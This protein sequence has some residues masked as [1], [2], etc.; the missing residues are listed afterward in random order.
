[1]DSVIGSSA[2]IAALVNLKVSGSQTTPLI[3]SCSEVI[4]VGNDARPCMRFDKNLRLKRSCG[5]TKLGK[6]TALLALR[7][8]VK[9]GT[10]F[11]RMHFDWNSEILAFIFTSHILAGN[12]SLYPFSGL[13][14]GT[15]GRRLGRHRRLYFTSRTLSGS[16][17][18]SCFR[19]GSP[20][21]LAGKRFE[22]PLSDLFHRLRSD[23]E[24][25]VAVIPSES[26]GDLSTIEL[27]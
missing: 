14:G 25:G 16:G 4:T 10:L 18:L 11:H 6:S 3:K 1:L 7:A 8:T 26:S 9:P 19:P 23:C 12:Q 17:G 21:R 20:R 2:V 13:S 27:S 22:I 5:A 15:A 24:F